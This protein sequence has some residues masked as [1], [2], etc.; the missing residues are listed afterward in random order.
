MNK[1]VLLLFAAVFGAIGAY[2]PVL[3]GDTEPLGGWSILGGL[4]GGL[5]GI[6]LGV[7]VSKRWG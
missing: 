6:W 4:F 2:L 3:F 1:K 5:F 7:I